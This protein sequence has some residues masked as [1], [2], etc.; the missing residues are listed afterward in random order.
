MVILFF[1]T[2]RLRPDHDQ[3]S[4]RRSHRHSVKCNTARGHLLTAYDNIKLG[5]RAVKAP[6]VTARPTAAKVK[7]QAPPPPLELPTGGS[8][9]FSSK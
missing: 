4:C 3:S 7:L 2:L 9:G 8:L 1:L 6:V 5:I